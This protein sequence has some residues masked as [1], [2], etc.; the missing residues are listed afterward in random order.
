MKMAN[1][2]ITGILEK[3]RF[4]F[5]FVFDL[6]NC[7]FEGLVLQILCDDCLGLSVGDR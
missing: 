3:V 2:Q 5:Y 4:L 7:V 1:L 6:N